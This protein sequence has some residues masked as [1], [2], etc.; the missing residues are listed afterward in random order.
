MI[1]LRDH[2]PTRRLPVVTYT[3]ISLNVLAFIL[4]MSLYESGNA[5]VVVDHGLV[6]ER[7]THHP[8][9]ELDNILTS[10]FMHSPD[11]WW[12]LG[13]NMLF[14]WIFGDNVEDALGR[15]RFVAFYL[16]AGVIAAIAQWAIDP[17]SVVPMV[18]ASGAIAGVLAGYGSL[19]PRAPVSVVNPIPI[20]WVFF[21]LTFVLPSWVI[22]L[23]F[24]AV[25][26]LNGIGSLRSQEGGVAFFA[27]LGGFV[28]GLVLVRWLLPDE[29]KRDAPEMRYA[30]GR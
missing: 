26:L 12:H 16:L 1:P 28:A 10:M 11:G 7:L 30:L 22:I 4:Q 9:G 8:L 25:N 3:L 5:R 6:P 2:L 17:T 20:L 18:G 24:F 19:Y 21:G 27:H 14:L 29:L 23:E 13:G 15:G